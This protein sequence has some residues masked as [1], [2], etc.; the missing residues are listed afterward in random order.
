M[1]FILLSLI[2][3]TLALYFIREGTKLSGRIEKVVPALCA[4][5][6]SYVLLALEY[7]PLRGFFIF[8]GVLAVCGLLLMLFKKEPAVS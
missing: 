2:C 4:L 6:L 1:L 5:T 8:L 3:C 7:A